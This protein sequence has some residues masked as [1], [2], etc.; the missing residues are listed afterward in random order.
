MKN[1]TARQLNDIAIFFDEARCHQLHYEMAPCEP[2]EFAMEYLK[3][4]PDEFRQCA[5]LASLGR[6][7]DEGEVES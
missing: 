5:D 4:W 2:I 7:L 6:L 1:I 3:R